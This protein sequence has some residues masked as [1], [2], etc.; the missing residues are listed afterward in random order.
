MATEPEGDRG[1][2]NAAVADPRFAAA[3]E[4]PR[5]RASTTRSSP[6]LRPARTAADASRSTPHAVTA[7]LRT[8]SHTT[9]HARAQDQHGRQPIELP[10]G[11]DQLPHIGAATRDV[12]RIGLAAAAIAVA[13][14]GGALLLA[15]DRKTIGRIGRRV[16]LLAIE[17]ALVFAL[18]PRLLDARHG[19]AE[20]VVAAIL[21]AYGRP[22]MWSAFAS[23]VAGVSTWLI[24]LALPLLGR[25]APDPVESRTAPPRPRTPVD[26]RRTG[27]P[28]AP[29]PEKLYL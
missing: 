21:R 18:L 14:V 29:L 5:S 9:I 8:A 11:N 20:A 16:A 26:R 24:S 17:P 27:E 4:R 15:H 10:I 19:N 23:V 22:V 6:T 2:C 25:P 1:D 3:F 13:L 7:A 12:G 28:P